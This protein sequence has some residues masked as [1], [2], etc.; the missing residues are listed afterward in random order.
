MSAYTSAGGSLKLKGVQESGIKKKKKKK[1]KNK[2]I[3][4]NITIPDSLEDRPDKTERVP[5]KSPIDRRTP[6]Q[7]AFAKV[8][9]KRQAE[10]ILN[11]AS[12][13]HKDRVAGFNQHLDKLTE[14]YDIPKVSWTK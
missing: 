14:H 5:E 4:D 10:K 9:E 7:K 11:K 2:K 3:L 1:N 8:Q 6:A 13:T 12:M